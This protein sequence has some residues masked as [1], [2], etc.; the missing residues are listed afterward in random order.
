M[1]DILVNL[2]KNQ[3][4]KVVEHQQV[5]ND[6]KC[7]PESVKEG[8]SNKRGNFGSLAIIP[9]FVNIGLI[10]HRNPNTPP[11]SISSIRRPANTSYQNESFQQS[12]Y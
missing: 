4:Y 2:E 7:L 1:I 3:D 12:D 10:R 5:E 9:S 8:M 11:E 6:Q